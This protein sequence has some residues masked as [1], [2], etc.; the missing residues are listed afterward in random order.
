MKARTLF[1]FL[2]GCLLILYSCTDNPG[3]VKTE[4]QNDTLTQ[5][6]SFD[7]SM[8]DSARMMKIEAL[9]QNNQTDEALL[10]IEQ[11]LKKNPANPAWQ[12][13]KADV[14]IRKKDTP[15][16]LSCY[17]SA[18]S[19]AGNFPQA[20]M[21]ILNIYAETGNPLTLAYSKQLLA[22]PLYEKIE[23]DILTMQGI[24]FT[25]AGNTN[26]ADAIYSK[27]I[28][29]DYTFLPAYIEKGLLYYDQKKYRQA[30]D[31]FVRATAVKNDF[32]EG[33]FWI[34][35]TCQKLDQKEDAILNFK[36]S[37]ALDPSIQEAREEL[38][39][40]GAIQ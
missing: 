22:D 39:T 19:L 38:K 28:Q 7:T 13:M 10:H 21:A 35:K 18:D 30:L 25:Q 27:I 11:L 33:Y 29:Q 24:Y 17:L 32:A 4:S 14:M 2:T 12:F 8:T 34:A 20:R 6:L 16:A 31:I 37:L 40:L 26:Q 15:S 9:V 36:R 5:N 23:S 1:V 3:K